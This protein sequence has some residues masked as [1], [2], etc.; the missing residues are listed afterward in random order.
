[1]DRRSTT[2]RN[3]DTISAIERDALEKRSVWA[4]IGDTIAIQAG[5]AWFIALNIACFTGWIWFNL[6]PSE[7]RAP[8]DPYPFPLLN[9]VVSLEAI[10]LA[11]FILM[12]QNRSNIQAEHR[13]HLDLQI[14]L[15]SEHENTKMLQMLTALCAHHQLVISGDQEIAEL[16]K[17]TEPQE[18]LEQLK[19][20]LP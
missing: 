13:N 17:R 12:S 6:A 8:F 15:L 19:K 14:N 5:R 3:I 10:F 1:M 9:L 20:N 18:V 11:M 2:E 4:R 16:A 7:G